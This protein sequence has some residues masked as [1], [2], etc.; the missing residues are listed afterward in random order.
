M[1]I[2]LFCVEDA[3]LSIVGLDGTLAES[4]L[5]HLTDRSVRMMFVAVLAVS[6]R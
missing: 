2:V 4:A 1:E 6:T 5:K 3:A